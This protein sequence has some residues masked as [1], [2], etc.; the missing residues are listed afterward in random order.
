VEE[1]LAIAKWADVHSPGSYV[2]WYPFMHPQL[3]SIELGGPDNFR[4]KMNPPAH[5]LLNEVT[6]HAEFALRHAML[7]P[8]L[9]ILLASANLVGPNRDGPDGEYVWQIRVGKG[10]FYVNSYQLKE[11]CLVRC[12]EYRFFAHAG[13][14]KC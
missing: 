13:D 2:H 9:E 4:L 7:S 11:F 5:M 1:E 8:K 6:P 12:C 14:C 10:C 3:G